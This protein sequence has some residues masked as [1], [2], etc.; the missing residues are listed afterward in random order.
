M[1]GKVEICGVNTTKLPTLTAAETDALLHRAKDGDAAAREKLVEGNLRLVLSVIQRFSGRGE[2]ADDLF[3]VGC[4]GLLKAI[5]NFDTSQ[6]VRFSTYGVPMIIG[7]IRRYLRDNSSIRVSRS[8]RDTAYR[9]LQA[10]EKL[11]REQQREPTVE[12]IARELGIRREEVVFAMDAVCDPVSLFEPI[13]SDG[14]DAVCVMDQVRDNKNTDEDWLEQIALKEAM[15][16]L[17]ER[18]RQ[19]LAL[20][21]SYYAQFEYYEFGCLPRELIEALYDWQTEIYQSIYLPQV[22][23]KVAGEGVYV[24]N[25]TYLTLEEFDKIIDGHHGSIHLVPCNCKSQKYFHDRKLNVCVNMNDGPN[26]AVDRGMGE[27]ISPENMK[28]KVREFNASGLMQNGEDGFICNCD[29]LCCFPMQMAYK[30]GSRLIYPESNW[31]I[32]WHEDE[33]VNCGKCTKI[34]NFGAFYKDDNRKVHYDVD[35]C[36]GCTICAPNCPKHAIHLL[37]REQKV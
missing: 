13:Y 22:K 15:A 21:Y 12:Q 17:S 26:S 10:R 35:K 7:E 28:K 6:N 32:D 8:M 34:C 27:P 11:Q 20:R 14:G 29:G 24:H 9:V 30:A 31:K 33:C 23:A 1:L 3:Q 37:P 4:V 25:Q 36:W 19:I 16:R 18:E 2:N 5:D